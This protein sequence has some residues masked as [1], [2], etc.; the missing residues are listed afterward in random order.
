MALTSMILILDTTELPVNDVS[1]PLKKHPW[2]STAQTRKEAGW[3]Q[4][5]HQHWGQC[6]VEMKE[7]PRIWT[8]PKTGESVAYIFVLFVSSILPPFRES[9]HNVENID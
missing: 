1:L 3:H 9:I 6:I 5:T 8:V 4:V 7:I 2:H